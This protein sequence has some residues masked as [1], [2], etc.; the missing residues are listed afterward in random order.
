MVGAVILQSAGPADVVWPH[1]WEATVCVLYA[2]IIPSAV[3]VSLLGWANTL[4]GPATVSMYMTLQPLAA[5]AMSVVFL[6]YELHLGSILSATLV[7]SG[8][9]VVTWGR[10]E[11]QR[12]EG[13][14]EVKKR[15]LTGQNSSADSQLS[16]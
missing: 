7:V 13:A 16:A 12:I 9:Y 14:G 1:T 8:L 10:S 15:D 4:V 6:G 5:S 3:N 11:C 2:A